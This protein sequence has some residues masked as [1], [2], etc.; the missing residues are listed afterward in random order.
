MVQDTIPMFLVSTNPARNYE[1]VGR[2]RVATKREV[3]AAVARAKKAQEQWGNYSAEERAQIIKKLIPLMT[4]EKE[5]FARLIVAEM[6]KP[7]TEARQEVEGAIGD[8]AHFV[9][10]GPG[11]V[12]EQIIRDDQWDHD[13]VLYEP[14][15]VAGVITPWNYPLAMPVWGV[16]PNLIVGNTVVFK[17]SEETPLTGQKFA[18]LLGQIGLPQEVF[19]VVHGKGDVGDMFVDAPLDLVWFTCSSKAGQKI[20]AK[21][22]KKFIKAV[23]ELGGSSPA[24]VCEDA[25][26]DGAVREI[27]TG[28][29]SNC[30]QVCTAVKRLFVHR[31]VYQ[32]FIKELVWQVAQIK[33]GDPMNENTKIGSLA[34]ERQLQLLEAQVED[35]VEKGA[36]ILFGGERPAGLKG[37][38]YLPTI[39]TN[40][41]N[42]MRVMQEEVFGPVLPVVA[43]KDFNQALA[44]ANNTPYGLSA[45]VFTSDKGRAEQA[46]RELKAGTVAVNTDNFFSLDCPFGGYKNSG[47][48]REHGVWGFREL[49]QVKHVRVKK[50]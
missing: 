13:T 1:E 25:N 21:A 4:R 29:F 43:F 3:I 32:K 22:G 15:G 2:V 6:G 36:K 7:I 39:L 44:L 31:R 12:A 38:Y 37:A 33:V 10:Q 41:K 5:T 28:R 46:A 30:G 45:E 23:L 35:A 47:M 17:P 49:V 26:L 9:V 27:V 50:K 14:W 19:S 42:T 18:D 16:I 40:V 20:F 11:F 34:A 48:G 24:I 8:V